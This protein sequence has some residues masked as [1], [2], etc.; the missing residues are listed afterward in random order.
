MGSCYSSV[1]PVS[2]LIKE[3][4]LRVRYHL[5]RQV[6]RDNPDNKQSVARLLE[7]S[8]ALGYC[9]H[10]IRLCRIIGT[11]AMTSK[12]FFYLGMWADA[13]KNATREDGFC[14][15][16]RLNLE[17]HSRSS[18]LTEQHYVFEAQLLAKQGQ[19]DDAIFILDTAKQSKL[20]NLFGF[21]VYYDAGMLKKAEQLINRNGNCSV[22]TLICIQQQMYLHNYRKAEWGFRILRKIKHRQIWFEANLEYRLSCALLMVNKANEARQHLNNAAM[23][24]F[25]KYYIKRMKKKLNAYEFFMKMQY[26]TS[27]YDLDIKY[28]LLTYYRL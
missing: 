22:L 12:C 1:D 19:I 14:K 27:L 28:S 13:I 2:E 24:G 11:H 9:D 4:D 8:I 15:Q 10:A 23:L 26:S 7:T 18:L 3:K 5:L 17:K 20:Y 21:W 6:V 16:S 25:K